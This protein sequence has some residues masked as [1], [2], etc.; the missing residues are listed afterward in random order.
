M[1]IR[2]CIKCAYSYI[3]NSMS[4]SFSSTVNCPPGTYQTTRIDTQLSADDSQSSIVV[5]QCT[6][7]P[8]GYYQPDQGQTSCDMCPPGSTSTTTGSTSCLCAPHHYSNT[9]YSPCTPCPQGT[10]SLI[11]G[12][13]ACINCNILSADVPTSICPVISITTTSKCK[14]SHIYDSN[15]Y[16]VNLL[17][18]SR[19]H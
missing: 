14:I 10:Y 12:S 7:C 3:S 6:E 18:I 11:D 16:I 9:G 4:V 19:T 13:T 5:P 2:F 15:L 8:V 17:I 1:I